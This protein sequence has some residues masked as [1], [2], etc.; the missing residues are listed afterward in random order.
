MQV[1]EHKMQIDVFN[2]LIVNSLLI[3]VNQGPCKAK[4]SLLQIDLDS[5]VC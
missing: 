1:T 4:L 3:D 5:K 2:K